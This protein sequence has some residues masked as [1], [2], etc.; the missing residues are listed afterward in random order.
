VEGLTEGGVKAGLPS[1]IA[2][3][4]T[5]KTV[6][7]SALTLEKTGRKPSELISLVA[8]KK[9]TTLEGLKVMKKRD[10]NQILIQTVEA[11]TKRALEIR[12]EMKR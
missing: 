4:L 5:L 1:S 7:G 2:Y 6:L 10:F 11:A 3:R 9:G 8:S 12:K